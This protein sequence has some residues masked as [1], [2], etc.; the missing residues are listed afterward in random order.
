MGYFRNAPSE[1]Q[2]ANRGAQFLFVVCCW[3]W[4]CVFCLFH[5]WGRRPGNAS[6]LGVREWEIERQRQWDGEK[7][8]LWGVGGRERDREGVK[9][10]RD[11][12]RC[13]TH[14][15]SAATDSSLQLHLEAATGHRKRVTWRWGV[16]KG[17]AG[18]DKG[19]VERQICYDSRSPKS[20]KKLLLGSDQLLKDTTL[21]NYFPL[22]SFANISWLSIQPSKT[23]ARFLVL[24]TLLLAYT[25]FTLDKITHQRP[26]TSGF[27]CQWERTEFIP[28][29][30]ETA[31]VTCV[32]RLQPWPVMKTLAH[33]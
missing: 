5:H 16:Q 15:H 25:L 30:N 27:C 33:H 21:A 6:S 31:V 9:A 28:A 18:G 24:H 8:R 3:W 26:Q 17:Q 19:R 13:Q 10:S 23:V 22:C 4:V 2:L 11:T 32:C 29:S 12:S 20:G 14:R 1:N 7:R